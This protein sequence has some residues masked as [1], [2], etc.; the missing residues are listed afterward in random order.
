[1]EEV[2][3]VH[4]LEEVKAPVGTL[5]LKVGRNIGRLSESVWDP[6][7]KFQTSKPNYRVIKRVGRA[8]L[9]ERPALDG[10]KRVSDGEVT[11]GGLC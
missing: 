10:G 4:E 9:S 5:L 7:F 11:S 8:E 2:R 1:L 6:R 3:E